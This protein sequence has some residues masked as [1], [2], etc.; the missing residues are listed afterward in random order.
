MQTPV[1]QALQTHHLGCESVVVR[2]IHHDLLWGWG[3]VDRRTEPSGALGPF[4]DPDA[5]R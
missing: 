5:I 1:E 4:D 3:G 2:L